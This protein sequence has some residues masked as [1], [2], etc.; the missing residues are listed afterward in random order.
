MC[1]LADADGPRCTKRGLDCERTKI[2]IQ[3][4]L[5][6]GRQPEM[7]A[8]DWPGLCETCLYQDGEPIVAGA[9]VVCRVDVTCNGTVTRIEDDIAVVQT[10]D[11]PEAWVPIADLV[12]V[13]RLE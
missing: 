1:V 5:A 8:P 2:M 4:C 12:G 13:L 7:I 3:R 9:K 11:G 10:T 6:C